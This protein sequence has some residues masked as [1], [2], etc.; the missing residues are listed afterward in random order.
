MIDELKICVEHL[1]KR[2]CKEVRIF[3][4]GQNQDVKNGGEC[5]NPLAPEI[6]WSVKNPSAHKVIHPNT[7]QQED[8]VQSWCLIEE[9][10]TDRREIDTPNEFIFMKEGKYNHGHQEE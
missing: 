8:D 9:K 10:D 3:E 1:V 4:V 7:D 5:D 2:T 6:G